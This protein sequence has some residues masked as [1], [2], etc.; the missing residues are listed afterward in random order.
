MMFINKI[1]LFL[2]NILVGMLGPRIVRYMASSGEG[3]NK[4]LDIGCLPVLTHF[5]QPIPDL[6]DLERRNVWENVSK[7]NGIIWKPQ[8]Y[9]ENLKELAKFADECDWPYEPVNRDAMEF[10]I[11]NTCFSYGCASMLH[12]IIRKN[13][14]KRII[15]VGSGHSS[16]VIA[17]ALKANITDDNG[18]YPEYTIIDPYSLLDI[19]KF[20]GNAKLLK[21]Q[22]ENVDVSI[23]KELSNNDIL[24][25]DS[26]HVCKIGSD[27][28]FEILEVLPTL[29]S[30]VFV[31][32]HDIELPYE[33]SKIYATNPKFRMFWTEQYLLQ[34]FLTCNKQ[35]EIFLPLCYIQRNHEDEFRTL[36]KKGNNSVLW[37]SGSFWIKCV[38]DE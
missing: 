15:E 4:C 31:H 18:Y 28:N 35:F 3:T 9:L 36:F 37:H 27:V 2:L 14:P 16:R 6:K 38:K 5:Y 22:V 24:F 10:Y 17:A 32:F 19:T 1:K 30:G 25:I 34:A 33:Y 29:N 11:N 13:K 26:S 12:S 8:K 7:L 23:F 20:P 21:E